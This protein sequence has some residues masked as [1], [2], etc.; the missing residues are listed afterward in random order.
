LDSTLH[1]EGS[2]GRVEAGPA[3]ELFNFVRRLAQD[4]L[5]RRMSE[6]DFASAIE[7]SAIRGVRHSGSDMAEETGSRGRRQK[8]AKSER[9]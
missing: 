6:A 8:G 3:E 4:V 9:L 5:V 7:V 1:L 2:A